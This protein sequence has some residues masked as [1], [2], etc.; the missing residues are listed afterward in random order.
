MFNNQAHRQQ[1]EL[2]QEYRTRLIAAV[3]TGKLDMRKVETNPPAGTDAYTPITLAD[4]LID[5][6]IG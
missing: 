3:V 6:T 4:G 1:I 5:Q 2:L